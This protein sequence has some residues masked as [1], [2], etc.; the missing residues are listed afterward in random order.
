[1]YCINILGV[2]D[3]SEFRGGFYYTDNITPCR[4]GLAIGICTFKRE[5]YVYK[6]MKMLEDRFLLNPNSELK[7]N[8]YI[9]ISDNAKTLDI[10]RFQSKHIKVYENKNAG[11]AGGFTRTIIETKK[12]EER[13]WSDTYLAYG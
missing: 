2:S 9:N 13:E 6:N 3:E 4:I 12:Q 8:L 7:D 1:M 10:E 5:K 11:G